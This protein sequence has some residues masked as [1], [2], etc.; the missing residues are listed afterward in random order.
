M[1]FFTLIACTQLSCCFRFFAAV[2]DAL[3]RCAAFASL[4]AWSTLL[5]AAKEM[6][7]QIFVQYRRCDNL[8][9][10]SQMR[11]SERSWIAKSTMTVAMNFCFDKKMINSAVIV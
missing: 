1:L 3:T 10:I 9:S 6:A 2:S 8:C 4:S 5:E 7:G 11:I